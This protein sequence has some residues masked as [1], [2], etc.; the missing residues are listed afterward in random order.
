MRNMVDVFPEMFA[1][2]PTASPYATLMRIAF[3]MWWNRLS[4]KREE[5][6]KLCDLVIFCTVRNCLSD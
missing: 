6:A 3:F 4:Q 5:K 2:L 1:M